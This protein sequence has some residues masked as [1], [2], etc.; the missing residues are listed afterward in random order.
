MPSDGETASFELG[1]KFG[2]L[3]HQFVGTPVSEAS[4]SSLE[5]A[6]EAA[7]ENQPYTESVAVAI[8]REA[9]AADV[10]PHGY[11]GLDGRHMDVEIAVDADGTR[12]EGSM[13]LVE[14]Y[15]RM[16]L[17]AVE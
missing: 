17:D 3:F 10:G 12:A 6:I 7:I 13:E 4:A 5:A 9:L 16:R 2:A 8:D 11:T 15:P 14:G 1:I